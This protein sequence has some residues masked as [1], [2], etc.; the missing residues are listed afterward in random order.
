M[1]QQTPDGA[2]KVDMS[3]FQAPIKVDL[4]DFDKTI[5]VDMSAFGPQAQQP[6]DEATLR[7]GYAPVGSVRSPLPLY[8]GDRVNPKTGMVMRGG[9]PS[10]GKGEVVGA[11]KRL[12]SLTKDQL[13]SFFGRPAQQ[14]VDP[15]TGRLVTTKP[16]TPDAITRGLEAGGSEMLTGM[17]DLG[18][19]SD[20]P[21][22]ELP[23]K[24]GHR[25]RGVSEVVG[26]ALK[27]IQLPATIGAVLMGPEAIAELVSTT[28]WG[29]GTAK[30]AA[31]GMKAVGVRQD[32]A[33]AASDIAGLGVAWKVGTMVR[34]VPELMRTLDAG[35]RAAAMKAREAAAP[36][37]VA[38]KQPRPPEPPG[39]GGTAAVDRQAQERVRARL[40]T[41]LGQVESRRGQVETADRLGGL[42]AAGAPKALPA[43]GEGSWTVDLPLP[44]V[45]APPSQPIGASRARVVESL[46]LGMPAGMAVTRE[47][48]A[49]SDLWTLPPLP[50]S[51]ASL[52]AP[53]DVGP[54]LMSAE[55]AAKGL[56][57]K[58]PAVL[59]W[60]R[61]P[62]DS[63]H[64]IATLADG[65]MAVYDHVLDRWRIESRT[66][67]AELPRGADAEFLA[68]QPL[69]RVVG[70]LPPLPEGR[71]RQTFERFGRMLAPKVEPAGPDS[72]IVSYRGPDGPVSV[73]VPEA[74]V[75][76]VAGEIARRYLERTYMPAAFVEL[77]VVEKA[78]LRRI[79]DEMAE[80]PH[81]VI[82]KGG[83]LIRDEVSGRQADYQ[84]SY[85]VA[86]APVLH[87]IR[88]VSGRNLTRPQI[89]DAINKY[90]AGGGL[91]VPVRDALV[92]ARMRLSG[93][94][95]LPGFATPTM[96]PAVLPPDTGRVGAEVEAAL[97]GTVAE[98]DI[99]TEGEFDALMGQ[100][101]QWY[102]QAAMRTMIQYLS[103]GDEAPGAAW[104]TQAVLKA[105]PDV[106]LA[107]KVRLE[108]LKNSKRE[109]KRLP[110]STRDAIEKQ[111]TYLNDALPFA[112]QK[113]WLKSGKVGLLVNAAENAKFLGEHPELADVIPD[114][115]SAGRPAEVVAR[116]RGQ[117]SALKDRVERAAKDPAAPDATSAPTPVPALVPPPGQ[118][119]PE[120]AQGQYLRD[121]FARQ[122][123]GLSPQSYRQWV[124]D[125][126]LRDRQAA[127]IA[128]AQPNLPRISEARTKEGGVKV[129]S[130]EETIGR[131]LGSSLY[132]GDVPKT[133]TR[134]LIQNAVDAVSDPATGE[135]APGAVRIAFAQGTGAAT[136]TVADSGKGMTREELET[137][138][139]DL[140]SSGKRDVATAR[141]GFGLA[142]ASILLGGQHAEIST[143]VDVPMGQGISRRMR[144]TLAGT[145]EDFLKHVDV[146][147]TPAPSEPTGTRI[148]VK[149]SPTA[150]L[151]QAKGQFERASEDYPGADSPFQNG[152]RLAWQD[153]ETFQA[154]G[155]DITIRQTPTERRTPVQGF[156]G[157]DVLNHGM[158][159]F[160]GGTLMNP[161]TGYPQRVT[162]DVRATVPEGHADYPFT[163]NRERLRDSIVKVVDKRVQETIGSQ[164]AAR[165]T[166]LALKQFGSPA[167]MAN[168]VPYIDNY[169]VWPKI[170]AAVTPAV[171]AFMAG[172]LDVARAFGEALQIPPHD[173]L[174]VIFSKETH[175]VNVHLGGDRGRAVYLNPVSWFEGEQS[176]DR[177]VGGVLHTI[178]HE[179]THDAVRGHDEKFTMQLAENYGKLGADAY[180][181]AIAKLYPLAR[182]PSLA[183]FADVA[184]KAVAEASTGR[185]AG[186]GLASRLGRPEDSSGA[187]GGGEDR[188]PPRG[189]A[190]GPAG[191][192]GPRDGD[193]TLNDEGEPEQPRGPYEGK[194]LTW[195]QS[196]AS[197][198]EQTLLNH[199]ATTQIADDVLSTQDAKT[200][201]EARTLRELEATHHDLTP[202]QTAEHADIMNIF[203]KP[204]DAAGHYSKRLGRMYSP[205]AIQSATAA[206]AVMRRIFEMLP[207]NATASG[208]LPQYI[209][210]YWSH[211]TKLLE[212]DQ[213]L[214]TGIRQLWKFWNRDTGY[215]SL[216]DAFRTEQ[217][218]GESTVPEREGAGVP[219]ERGRGKRTPASRF[220]KR[221][222]GDMQGLEYDPKVVYPVYVRSIARV[223]FDKPLLDR[224]KPMI[225]ELP[226]SELRELT[227]LW[228]Q[229]YTK[230]DAYPKL[231]RRWMAMTKAAMGLLS[232]SV[233]YLSPRLQLLHVGRTEAAFAETRGYYLKGWADTLKNP[234]RAFER[235]A[236]AGLLPNNFLP[237]AY[238]PFFTKL[239]NVGNAMGF[240]DF[241]D[242][243]VALH[244][245]ERMYQSQ[246][247]GADEAYLLAIRHAK[248]VCQVTDPAR[249]L[250]TIRYGALG[251]AVSQYKVIPWRLIYQMGE[252]W[253]LRKQDP[254]R[255]A[256]HVAIVSA[257][258]GAEVAGGVHLLHTGSVSRLL[259]FEAPVMSEVRRIYQKIENGDAMGFLEELALLAVPGGVSARTTIDLL[260][261]RER[262]PFLRA[263]EPW[264]KLK[265]KAKA[266]IRH[267]EQVLKQAVHG[268]RVDLPPATL[269]PVPQPGGSA[270]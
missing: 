4:S 30:A 114:P 232:R 115:G 268:R 246:G 137:V 88:E 71:P 238:R 151:W 93:A 32:I 247:Y 50:S 113:A 89:I 168:G 144:Y 156:L 67:G 174:G 143:V 225:K 254:A 83:G 24:T 186:S 107:T 242:R 208:A 112:V 171:Q 187:A 218:G 270:R 54:R 157:Y 189:E 62:N 76:E 52:T 253:E 202:E 92:V 44:V 230:F 266:E 77:P 185:D 122:R 260:P 179:L 9:G 239:D 103:G 224:V 84:G 138:F 34:D 188:V 245:F 25:A 68:K 135:L 99:N 53:I 134:E 59:G 236:V 129:G 13:D 49:G 263:M 132:A 109:W 5:Q 139:T 209:E 207:E 219:W 201:W 243:S 133:I 158:Y 257:F 81:Q 2:I 141:G 240:V 118:L 196:V 205:E 116:E 204:E 145:P 258:A 147:E 45:E 100:R 220:L 23:E 175:G 120:R 148:H 264:T 152:P 183:R 105:S 43:P 150:D 194:G 127:R 180:A 173:V 234:R 222:T 215:G 63:L 58:E 11:A 159:Q 212:N 169:G 262:A 17:K 195:M 191:P 124:A 153:V 96:R 27:A 269:P 177:V 126:A 223:V 136:I 31:A 241:L 227:E 184:R 35:E 90:E 106:A 229:N 248:K 6:A 165:Q 79:R 117:T 64:T 104:P 203:E 213:D 56:G 193:P 97:R 244:G 65:R 162:V 214:L 198:V 161:G 8:P 82:P 3:A 73:M 7:K 265:N 87:D 172:A 1:P 91:T 19:A 33:D 123:D 163:A 140:G 26:G 28:L 255:F 233:L 57:Q 51:E 85:Y 166:A 16:G 47:L 217:I 102:Q 10:L 69:P 235:T 178:V 259:N 21:M 121:Q 210:G 55:E 48:P 119:P 75:R 78:A 61:P 146:Q 15:A 251:Q 70:A 41:F 46:E 60:Y 39:G 130:A 181:D 192:G 261:P 42:A 98:G 267:E 142:K 111:L 182:D 12:V 18:L 237:S 167:R 66:G 256:R 94:T 170:Q 80:Q 199:P 231:S 86:G 149:L 37:Y 164:A 38:A 190:P 95:D 200:V 40:G 226:Q 29:M 249:V 155:A 36:Q 128:P 14:H 221:R 228:M 252:T 20:R 22:G 216:L 72:V 110:A 197:P 108:A 206:R 131:I 250:P 154:P 176:A 125:K 160:E 101:Q 74:R 211:I